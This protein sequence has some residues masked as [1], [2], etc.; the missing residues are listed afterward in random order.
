MK[1]EEPLTIQP[2]PQ[3]FENVT[4]PRE[5][6]VKGGDVYSVPGDR[7]RTYPSK[8]Q[9]ANGRAFIKESS[10]MLGQDAEITRPAAY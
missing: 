4:L 9:R 8:P 10:R 2:V 6:V 5:E 3:A 7:H 1:H